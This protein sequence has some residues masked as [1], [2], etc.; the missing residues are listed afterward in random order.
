MTIADDMSALS[1]RILLIVFVIIPVLISW[2][3]LQLG[4][5]LACFLHSKEFEFELLHNALS[6]LLS[7]LLHLATVGLRHSGHVIPIFAYILGKIIAMTRN[8]CNQS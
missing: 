1:E 3:V 2:L 7:T 8:L 5:P 4:Y 6:T